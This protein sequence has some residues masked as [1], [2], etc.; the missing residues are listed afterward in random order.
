MSS[1]DSSSAWQ[2]YALTG[3]PDF[4]NYHH[5]GDVTW[6]ELWGFYAKR[7]A[8]PEA[9]LRLT[10]LFHIFQSQAYDGEGCVL[11]RDGEVYHELEAWVGLA[12][13]REDLVPEERLRENLATLLAQGLISPLYYEAVFSVYVEAC[14]TR[15]VDRWTADLEALGAVESTES[16]KLLRG[17]LGMHLDQLPRCPIP[18]GA[19]RWDTLVVGLVNRHYDAWDLA[20]TAALGDDAEGWQDDGDGG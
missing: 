3:R 1:L 12:M 5:R 19:D 7:G 18:S 2:G 20:Y 17:R 15:S 8:E 14:L 4:L 13:D 9:V 16:A 10:G 6:S 11:E